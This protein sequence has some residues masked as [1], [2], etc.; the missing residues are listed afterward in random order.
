[1]SVLLRFVALLLGT[2]ITSACTP[3][4]ANTSVHTPVDCA[5][6]SDGG[7]V[8]PGTVELLA[9]L[10]KVRLANPVADLDANIASGDER[11]IGVTSYTCSAPGLGTTDAPVVARFHTHCL[12]GTG[13]IIEGNLHSAL[14]DAATTYARIYNSELLSRIRSGK[15]T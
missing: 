9:T 14:I 8:G 10:S 2:V 13:D 11:F 4:K 1:M 12:E 15:V 3:D 5:F 6:H 7:K